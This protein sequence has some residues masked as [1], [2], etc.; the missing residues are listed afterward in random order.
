MDDLLYSLSD[1]GHEEKSYDELLREAYKKNEGKNWKKIAEYLQD[2]THTQCLHRWQK[3]LNP[4]LVKGAWTKE[5]D[6][7]LHQLVNEYGPKNWSNIAAQLNGRIGKQCRERWYNHL[8]PSIRKDAW[9]PEEDLIIIDAHA[10][11]GNRWADIAK[12]LV[13]RPSNAI[14]NHWNSTLKRKVQNGEDDIYL[15]ELID[16]PKKRNFASHFTHSNFK[17]GKYRKLKKTK[18]IKSETEE[19]EEEEDEIE[20]DELVDDDSDYLTSDE[21]DSTITSTTEPQQ[22]QQQE[23]PQY[24]YYESLLIPSS[25]SFVLSSDILQPPISSSSPELDLTSLETLQ[26]P[27][28]QEKKIIVYSTPANTIPIPSSPATDFASSQQQI[29]SDLFGG[30]EFSL[31][32]EDLIFPHKLFCEDQFEES[33][34]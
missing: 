6:Q 14:K 10:K 13:G 4:K 32:N 26:S 21:R 16:K 34:F 31:P 33:S 18:E 23:P 27:F 29:Y 1:E 5:E 25:P 17:L 3:V 24:L 30:E 28:K 7:L 19:E 15:S 9:A 8:D 12:L 20:S 2:R 22:Q 11:L